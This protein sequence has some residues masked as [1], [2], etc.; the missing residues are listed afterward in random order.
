MPSK[1]YAVVDKNQCVACGACMNV[2]PKEAV[3]LWKGCYAAPAP[4][5]CI[6]CGKCA[7]IC[8]AGCIQIRNR[9]E[10]K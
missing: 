8:P 5:K 4:D 2:C 9:G 6:G 1:K 3:H 7:K 10:Q